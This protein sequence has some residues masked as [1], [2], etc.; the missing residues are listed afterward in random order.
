MS[1]P[2]PRDRDAA[3][4]RP[5]N[6]ARYVL[7]GFGENATATLGIDVKYPTSFV[8][9]VTVLDFQEGSTAEAAGIEQFDIILEV[10]SSPVGLIRHRFYEPWQ[11]YGR[12][13]TQKVEVLNSFLN[14][15]GERKYYY[16]RI[17]LTGIQE[18]EMYLSL[19]DD[20]FVTG[21]PRDRALAEDR[22]R[23]VARYVFGAGN[24]E[25]YAKFELGV[26]IQ[27]SLDFGA[28]IQAIKPGKAADKAHL[29]VGDSILEVDGAPIGQFGDRLY[30]LW[31]QYVFSKTGQ[32]EL[33]VC[34]V[35]AAGDFRYYY[36]LVQLDDLGSSN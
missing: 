32:V 26:S 5:T 18:V 36:P 35:D 16:P 10:D 1:T 30:E 22:D 33:L 2:K 4:D 14:Q 20:F 21:K 17:S 7:G 12:S 27:Y 34:Y 3:E 13:G 29:Q 11:H 31:R 28:A 6:L 8:Q 24:F 9:G 25:K 19:P 15:D 23:N